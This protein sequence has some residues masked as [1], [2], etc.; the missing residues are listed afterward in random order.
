MEIYIF[1]T[2]AIRFEKAGARGSY[3]FQAIRPAAAAA[4]FAGAIRHGL[5]K[6]RTKIRREKWQRGAKRGRENEKAQRGDAHWSLQHN[7]PEF[8]VVVVVVVVLVVDGYNHK[9]Q[10]L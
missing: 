5:S 8:R 1:S 6:Q 7:G 3:S 10:A 2:T 4:A 9:S